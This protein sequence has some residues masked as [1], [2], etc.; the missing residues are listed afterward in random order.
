[1]ACGIGTIR[2]FLR[3]EEMKISGAVI[4]GSMLFF[5]GCASVAVND[6]ALKSRTSSALGLSPSDFTISNRVDNGVRT[7]Y[8][9][10]AKGS[11][12]NCYVTGVVS[13]TGRTVSDAICTQMQSA[14]AQPA[15]KSSAKPTQAPAASCNALLKAA[16]KC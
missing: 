12:Y 3:G 6:D 2:P 10:Q 4:L 8:T 16:G 14:A 1:M 13:V 9:V 15:S 5:A 7:D 11:T